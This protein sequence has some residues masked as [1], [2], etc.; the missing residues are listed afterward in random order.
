MTRPPRTPEGAHPS[1][2]HRSHWAAPDATGPAALGQPEDVPDH[3]PGRAPHRQSAGYRILA[4]VCALLILLMI[5]VTCVD[6]FGRYVLNRPFAGAFE[7]TQV[8]LAALVFAA[9]PLTSADGGHVEVDLVLHLVPRG[10]Q[11]LLGRLA[12]IVS[13]LVLA[14]FAW[15]LIKIGLNQWGDGTRTPSLALPLAPLAFLAAASCTLSAFVMALRRP[16]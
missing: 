14:Y 3:I 7:L 5:G 1:G 12:G 6:V 11:R 15:R 13:A 2:D 9:L 10:V 4:G 8:L 16:E